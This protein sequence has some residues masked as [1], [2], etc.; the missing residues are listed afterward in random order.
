[1]GGGHENSPQKLILGLPDYGHHWTTQ[2]SA[3]RSTKINFIW[4]DALPRRRGELAVGGREL[5]W[6]SV[7]QTPWYRWNDGTNWH[8]VWFDNAA[9]LGLKYDLVTEHNLKGVGMWR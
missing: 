7:S 4:L 9:S 8:Q 3:P 1:M 2:T 5:L 6:D